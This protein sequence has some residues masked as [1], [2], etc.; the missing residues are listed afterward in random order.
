MADKND[1]VDKLA[2]NLDQA[3]LAVAEA[4]RNVLDGAGA[5]GVSYLVPGAAIN[6]LGEAIEA[7]DAA[8]EAFVASRERAL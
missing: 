2:D 7:W 6:A 5:R 4:A 8:T 1:D 3:V